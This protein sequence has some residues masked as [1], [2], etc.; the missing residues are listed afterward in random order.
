MEVPL[1]EEA[2]QYLVRVSQNGQLI[3]ETSTN[4]PS[5]HY[6]YALRMAD[7]VTGPVLL[8]VAQSSASY[9]VGPARHLVV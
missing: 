2:E 8:S 1:G 9:G 5:W 6:A 4:V 7:G 3:R